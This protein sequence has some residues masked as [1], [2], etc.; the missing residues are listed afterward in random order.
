MALRIT[1]NS[2]SECR[3]VLPV[4]TWGHSQRKCLVPDHQLP[5]MS[6]CRAF[7]LFYQEKP[8]GLHTFRPYS[9]ANVVL[10]GDKETPQEVMSPR[11]G[12]AGEHPAMLLAV[13]MCRADPCLCQKDHRAPRR[14]RQ[15]G[16][17]LAAPPCSVL[18][19]AGSLSFPSLPT[20]FVP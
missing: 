5:D 2:T 17:G 13:S 11:K 4:S 18:H 7:T 10:L 19:T 12:E 1:G 15:Q 16:L 6:P 8:A 14:P 9:G 20:P 3:P